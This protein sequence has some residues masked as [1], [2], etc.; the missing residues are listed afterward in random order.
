MRMMTIIVGLLAAY[1]TDA[2]VLHGEL[3]R[4][5]SQAVRDFGTNF[6]QQVTWLIRPLRR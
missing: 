2:T 3:T 6:N 4:E 5:A 1:I